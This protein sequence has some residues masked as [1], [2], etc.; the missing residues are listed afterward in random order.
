MQNVSRITEAHQVDPTQA[1]HSNEHRESRA[2]IHYWI[3]RAVWALLGILNAAFPGHVSTEEGKH[4]FFCLIFYIDLKN[5]SM[6][7][8]YS[9]L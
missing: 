5:E 3:K 2:N 8:T 6:D 7:S 1:F 9:I 4:A